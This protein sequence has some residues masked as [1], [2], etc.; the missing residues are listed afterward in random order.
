MDLSGCTSSYPRPALERCIRD[1]RLLNLL[2]K[3]QQRKDIMDTNIE[4]LEGCPFCDFMCIFEGDSKAFC[5][6]DTELCGI[7]SC[8]RCH[9]GSQASRLR[10]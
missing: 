6:Q 7:I 1:K 2:D 3:M 9:L 4:G 8:R 10:R 5:C